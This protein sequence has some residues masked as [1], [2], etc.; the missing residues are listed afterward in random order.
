VTTLAGS[1]KA[2][3]KDADVVERT[4]FLHLALDLPPARLFQDQMEQNIIPQVPIFE[5]AA[6]RG[7]VPG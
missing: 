2:A 4:P 3:G 7:A 5:C 1:G 6:C